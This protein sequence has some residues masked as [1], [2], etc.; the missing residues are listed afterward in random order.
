[1]QPVWPFW[2]MIRASV[3]ASSV[4][5][6]HRSY[7]DFP[8]TSPWSYIH[9]TFNLVPR[10]FP[11]VEQRPW[12]TLV[13]WPIENCSPRG[14][15][16]SFI[17]HV[18]TSAF[19]TS[20]AG[21]GRSVQSSLRIIYTSKYLLNWFLFAFKLY[22]HAKVQVLIATDMS[23]NQ[24]TKTYDR[25]LWNIWLW[26]NTGF[27]RSF[28]SRIRFCSGFGSDIYNIVIIC[29]WIVVIWKRY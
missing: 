7:I 4:N 22:K 10:L 5:C 21:S 17:I 16:K 24:A 29:H 25:M 1:M 6:L 8:S 27:G 2:A 9:L 19:H 13:T 14:G 15:W 28:I 11:L 18:S 12:W 23:G 26:N 20:I 3:M